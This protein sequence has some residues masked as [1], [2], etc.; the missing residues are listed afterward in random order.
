MSSRMILDLYYTDTREN[1][2]HDKHK[3]NVYQ[4]IYVT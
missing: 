4:M 1:A 3:H 2:V